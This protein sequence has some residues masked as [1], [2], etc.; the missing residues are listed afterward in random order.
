MRLREEASPDWTK[1]LLFWTAGIVLVCWLLLTFLG[2]R[3][4]PLRAYA[5]SQTCQSSVHY[6]ARGMQ[7]YAT[8]YEDRLP[9]AE[10]WMDSVLIYGAEERHLHCPTVSKPL[11][12]QFGYAMNSVVSGKEQN[13]IDAPD[14]MPLVYDSS[15]LT[16]NAHDER[17]SLPVPARHETP[18]M[19]A[20]TPD[21]QDLPAR[22]GNWIG[23]ADGSGRIKLSEEH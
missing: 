7:I 3:M 8:D 17:S 18:P 4:A 19:K 22:K 23:Y 5:A 20:R 16:R 11:E 21:Q 6:L 10:N 14:K 13:K 12:A 9:L 15:D 1:R 2:Q